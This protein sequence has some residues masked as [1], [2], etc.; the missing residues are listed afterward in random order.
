MTSELARDLFSGI[1]DETTDESQKDPPENLFYL[2]QHNP[3]S[4]AC[5][6]IYFKQKVQQNKDYGYKN[7][8]EDIE[9]CV[10]QFH[11]MDP[12]LSK[13]QIIQTISAT[14]ATKAIGEQSPELLHVFDFL[15]SCSVNNP[16]PLSIFSHHLK[17]SQ[18]HVQMKAEEIPEQ[19]LPNEDL[20]A[21]ATFEQEHSLWS[22]R[23]IVDRAVNFY[24][25]I[26]MEVQAI[27]GLLGYGN[28][29][30]AAQLKATS[31]GLEIIRSCPLFLI[32]NEPM[33]GK[34]KL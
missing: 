16:I 15:G 6:A 31:D 20:S 23:G 5:A 4:I 30:L 33:A 7:L 28:A 24:E 32:S 9:Q 22:F 3:L 27:K 14:L 26:K 1:M 25:R 17:T 13:L 29:S 10:K 2:L 34:L 18:F 19:D 21:N 11:E 8:Y 12:D